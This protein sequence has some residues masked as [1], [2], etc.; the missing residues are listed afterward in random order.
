MLGGAL[1]LQLLVV[2]LF[3]DLFMIVVSFQQCY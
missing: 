2:Q 3:K 1:L